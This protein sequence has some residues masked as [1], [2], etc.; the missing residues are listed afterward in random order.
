MPDICFGFSDS[1]WRALSSQLPPDGKW[2]EAWSTAIDVF[3]RRMKERYFSCIE[4]LI[5]ADSKPD[6]KADTSIQHCVPGF[7]ILALCCLVIET[8]QSFREAPPKPPVVTKTCGYPSSRECIK[9]SSG[10][11]EMFRQFLIRPAFGGA[12]SGS[13]ASSFV[14]GIRNGILHEAETRK[15]LI[16]REDTSD[17]LV[18]IQPDGRH[19]LNRNLF[20]GAL[21][22]EFQHY[23]VELQEPTANSLRL[24]FIE[25]MNGICKDA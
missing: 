19:A 4:A 14:R 8:L 13:I 2:T 1:D 6:H 5:N 22:Q 25:K 20:Y 3:E 9:P 10:T 11:S 17:L 7:A 16:W 15:W 12:F 23:L 24:R 21:K 18:E